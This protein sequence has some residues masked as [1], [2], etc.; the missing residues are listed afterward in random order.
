MNMSDLFDKKPIIGMVHCLPLPGTAKYGGSMQAVKR[1]ALEDARTLE[2]AGVDAVMVE[3]MNDD[4]VGVHM[5]AEQFAA[6]A[7]VSALVREEISVPMGV[8]AA[9]CDWEASLTIAYA[10]GADF[11]RV[12]V[13]VDAVMTA[14]GIV[15]PSA[16]QVLCKRRQLGAESIKLLCDVQVKHSHML[17]PGISVEESARMAVENGADAIIVTGAHTGSAAPIDVLRQLRRWVEIPLLVGSGFSAENAAE[18]M[19]LIDG[20]IVGS[21]FKRGGSVMGPI[22]FE[23]T[24][25]VMRAVKEAREM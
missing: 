25:E 15:M 17:V 20:A 6:L 12:P 3:N 8:D 11:I 18:Q 24:S 4:P 7:A 1:R 23:L 21:A 10:V 16:R 22:D 9:F 14:A 19:P 2:R 5:D 13:F